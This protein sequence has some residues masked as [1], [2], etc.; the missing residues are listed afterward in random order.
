MEYV[1]A[2]SNP[3]LPD[4]ADSRVLVGGTMIDITATAELVS[5]VLTRARGKCYDRICAKL[6]SFNFLV[7]SETDML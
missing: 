1:D 7:R 4:N 3:V 2:V 5:K 6:V